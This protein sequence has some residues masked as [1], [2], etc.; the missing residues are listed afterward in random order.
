MLASV[1]PDIMLAIGA[2]YG[3]LGTIGFEI[4]L[5]AMVMAWIGFWNWMR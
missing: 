2:V 4:V 1:S 5:L 3:V